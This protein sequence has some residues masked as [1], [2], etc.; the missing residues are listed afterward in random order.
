MAVI[1]FAGWLLASLT[2]YET[3]ALPSIPAVT[4][5]LA[6][7][8][9][10]LFAVVALYLGARFLSYLRLLRLGVLLGGAC[11]F[12][13]SGGIYAAAVNALGSGD[14]LVYIVAFSVFGMLFTVPTALLWWRVAHNYALRPT[15]SG[16]G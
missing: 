13:L 4:L 11:V 1:C 6:S 9:V 16:G 3:A 5:V 14:V 15:A 12:S 8:A 10:Y 2:P 7:P